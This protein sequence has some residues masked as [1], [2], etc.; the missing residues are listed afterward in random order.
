VVLFGRIKILNYKISK[1]VNSKIAF[2]PAKRKLSVV[3]KI[4]L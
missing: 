3:P 4:D 1:K 2:S